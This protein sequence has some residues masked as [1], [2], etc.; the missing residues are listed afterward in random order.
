VACRNVD[1]EITTKTSHRCLSSLISAAI[2]DTSSRR[3]PPTNQLCDSSSITTKR[4]RW[5][6][7]STDFVLTT[8]WRRTKCT[9][10]KRLFTVKESM[11]MEMRTWIRARATRRW[12]DGGSRRI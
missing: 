10:E 9:N 3:T 2:N 8:R 5:Q 7:I 1:E 11:S 6:S 4:S 12:R